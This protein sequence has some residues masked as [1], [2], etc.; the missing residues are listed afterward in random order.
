M[1][2]EPMLRAK[3]LSKRYDDGTQ[4]LDHLN[5]EVFPGQIYG[6]LGAN[7]AGKTTTLNLFLDFIEPTTGSAWIRG[8]AVHENP[9]EAKRHVGYVAENV[10]LYGNLSAL[11]N[12][13][14]FA[15]LGRTKP[16]GLDVYVPLLRRVGL[17]ER[18]FRQRVRSFSKGMRQKLGIAIAMVKN[19]PAL[20]LDEPTSG[21]DPK[22]AEDFSEILLELKAEGKAILMS[23]HDIFRT[24]ELCDRVGIMKG[25]RLIMERSRQELEMVDL[26]RIYMDYMRADA[27]GSV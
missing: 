5:L 16:M 19:A 8:I 25:G 3:D 24:K 7:G 27:V 6:L 26:N 10:L 2:S 14:F 11:Q 1:E 18:S 9:V 22:A 21:L 4:G 23:T 20:L 12:L 13:D 15:R 17:P